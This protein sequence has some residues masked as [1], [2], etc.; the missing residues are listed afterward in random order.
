VTLG[1]IPGDLSRV[2][3]RGLCQA[4]GLYDAHSIRV[5]IAQD[6]TQVM[7]ADYFTTATKDAAGRLI[8]NTSGRV[9]VDPNT[10][11]PVG[12]LGLHGV[13]VHPDVNPGDVPPEIVTHLANSQQADPAAKP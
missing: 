8:D 10:P 11:M 1:H 3:F 4:L 7:I 12:D 13:V 6:A 2:D 9:M 5:D